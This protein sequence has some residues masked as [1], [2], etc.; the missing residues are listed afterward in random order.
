MAG[1]ATL[2]VGRKKGQLY[3]SEAEAVAKGTAEWGKILKNE[4]DD[5][6]D[7]I[8]EYIGQQP[9]PTPADGIIELPT[10]TIKSIIRG[11]R[12]FRNNGGVGASGLRPRHIALLSGPTLA[13]AVQIMKDIEANARLP[14]F[15]R[16]TIMRMINKKAKGKRQTGVIDTIVRVWARVRFHDIG[17]I[18]DKRIDR[19]FFRAAPGCSAV[20]SAADHA[21]ECELTAAHPGEGTVSVMFDFIKY[22]ESLQPRHVYEA[23]V[24]VGVPPNIAIVL[25]H[26]YLGVRVIVLGE[27]YGGIIRP[28]QGVIPG[29]TWATTI[30]RC[31]VLYLAGS[32]FES[33]P[34]RVQ[35]FDPSLR[36]L[37]SIYIDDLI[38]TLSGPRHVLA[39]A[40][41]WLIADLVQAIEARMQ[42]GWARDEAAILCSHP[43][44]H[45]QLSKCARKFG[46][47]QPASAANLGVDF[48]AGRPVKKRGTTAKR[49]H[50]CSAR[51]PKIHR[52]KAS[53]GNAL[54]VVRQG[55]MTSAL[56]GAQVLGVTNTVLEEQRRWCRITTTTRS[57][58]A[59]TT[60]VL[61]LGDKNREDI[62]PACSP[63]VF[64][65]AFMVAAA[66]WDGRYVSARF[67]E[68]WKHSLALP[69][70]W[71]KVDGGER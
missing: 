19:P 16:H 56:Y 11:A 2:P 52:L 6:F 10:L 37:T 43:S 54:A 45:R 47:P 57:K 69:G 44:L 31:V 70:S 36:V 67:R 61:A 17:S 49:R 51:I 50:L 3:R 35:S 38:S 12:S 30:V 71:A 32:W 8:L 4:Q 39:A 24:Y 63:A 65:C 33:L 59:P 66:A 22:Y 46:I 42:Q 28:T 40:A 62:D 53:G 26:L 34:R 20:G 7:K 5:P 1:A 64:G 60:A 9:A 18:I 48:A 41:E 15:C 27:A 68:A 13:V 21:I 58:T 23:L 29:C 14:D 55:L 25:L